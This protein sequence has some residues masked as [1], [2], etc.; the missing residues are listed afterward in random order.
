MKSLFKSC[1]KIIE[2]KERFA[3]TTHVNPDGDG[4]G[5]EVA[6]AHYLKKMRK[7]VSIIN[8]SATPP[9]Y[10]FLD[11][12]REIIHFNP[13]LHLEK[14]RDAEVIF[15]IDTNHLDRLRSLEP[16]VR[17]SKAVKICVDH[18]LDK[19][20]F[21]DYYLIDEPATATGEIIYHLLQYL[22]GDK[23]DTDIARALYTAIMTD[24]GSFR[25]PKTDPEIHRVAAHLIECGANPPE[26]FQEVYEKG[27][28]NTLQLLGKA[29]ANLTTTHDGKVAYMA[30]TREMFRETGTSEFQTDN[31]IDYTMRIA[32]VQ[33]GLLFNELPEGV[34]ISFRSKG[35]IPVNELAKEFGGNGHLNAAGARLA[36][37]KLDETAAAVLERAKAYILDS[38]M[39]NLHLASHSS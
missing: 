24:T 29:L 34:K 10:Q 12:N 11:P 30:V 38:D 19:D 16:F 17:D 22:N 5:S 1:K 25:F 36:D 3:L 32:G 35:N 23:I 31:F 37:K 18:H 39:T 33:I 7:E 6:L 8:Y 20:D 2:E 27:P 15:I 26:I 21:A 13:A 14:I 4:L 9:N 28:I